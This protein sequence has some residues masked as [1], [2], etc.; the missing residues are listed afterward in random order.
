MT[1]VPGNVNACFLLSS[2]HGGD[3]GGGAPADE[4]GVRVGDGGDEEEDG[5]GEGD[6]GED[7]LGD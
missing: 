6:E 4:E 3:A 2:D 1:P 7:G 5:L